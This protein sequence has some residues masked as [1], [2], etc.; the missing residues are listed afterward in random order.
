MSNHISCKKAVDLISKKEEGKLSAPQRFQL[1]KHLTAC[2]LCRIFAVQNKT[3]QK[4]LSHQEEE[5]LS[6]TDKQ[7]IIA[8]VLSGKE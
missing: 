6:D 3:I 8:H 7:K 5:Q 4:V 2:S 1:W